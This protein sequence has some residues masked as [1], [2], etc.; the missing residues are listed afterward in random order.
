VC[1]KYDKNGWEFALKKSVVNLVS[2]PVSLIT[3]EGIARV[4]GTNNRPQ[5]GI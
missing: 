4:A 3:A 2:I 1:G 5:L